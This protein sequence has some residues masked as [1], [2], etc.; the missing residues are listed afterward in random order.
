[1]EQVLKVHHKQD[2]NLETY[3][4]QEF[5]VFYKQQSQQHFNCVNR[6]E[7]KHLC[8][9]ITSSTSLINHRHIL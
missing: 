7:L 8:F 3:K 6:E 1:M 2:T 4:L 9:S 5:Q